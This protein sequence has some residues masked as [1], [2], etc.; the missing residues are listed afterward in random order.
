MP[1]T[2]PRPLPDPEGH[3]RRSTY[4]EEDDLGVQPTQREPPHYHKDYLP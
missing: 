1:L 2:G 4:Q 3:A